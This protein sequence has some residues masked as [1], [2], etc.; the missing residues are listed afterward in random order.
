MSIGVQDK[1]SF[2]LIINDVEVDLEQNT[3]DYFH[4]VESV[5]LHLPMATLKIKDTTKFFSRND[6]LVDGVPVQVSIGV[7][8]K[9]IVYNM[10]LFSHKE[11]PDSGAQT[12]RLS[13]L[14]DVPQYWTSSS[15]K[16][17]R[18]TVSGALR[19]ICNTVGLKYVGPDT[20]DQQIWIPRNRKYQEFANYLAEHAYL[21]ES[22]CMKLAVTFDKEMLLTNVADFS[23]LSVKQ[24]LANVPDGKQ[25]PINDWTIMNK[26]GFFNSVNGYKDTL[27]SQ[28][29]LKDDEVTKEAKVIKNSQR[30]MINKEVR[31]QVGQN[32]VMYAP[33]DVGNTNPYYTKAPYQN[34]RLGNLFS[35]G[36][37]IVTT[38]SV[39]AKL[40]EVVNCQIARPDITGVSSIS[41]NY[42]VISKIMY[43]TNMNLFQK[44]EV[45]RQGVN[46]N[47]DTELL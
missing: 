33:I 21:D 4:A 26:S 35:T 14:L 46:D 31:N 1:L 15:V 39:N 30:I 6:V 16:I 7:S 38:Q 23:K 17:L 2:Q 18:T 42:M 9:K 28:S 12:Y 29:I 13:L 24:T 27:V 5:R 3:I 32:R 37:E 47:T 41:G 22:S 10:R 34:Q 25:L 45:A 8:N 19:E 20:N 43:I 11:E 44:I 36:L 40:M